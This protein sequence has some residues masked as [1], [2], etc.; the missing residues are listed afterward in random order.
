MVKLGL[1]W[2]QPL[3]DFAHDIHP[4]ETAAIGHEAA[5]GQSGR[6]SKARPGG[7]PKSSIVDGVFP[8]GAP[9]H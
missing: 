7:S 3:G 6:I 2:I 8:D 1:D 5:K 4:P 9:P